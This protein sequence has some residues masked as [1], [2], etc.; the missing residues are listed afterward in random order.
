MSMD[1]KSVRHRFTV[2]TADTKVNEW[3]ENQSNLGFS[4][5]VLIKAFV[6]EYGYQDAT[7]LELG[8]EVKRRGRP[9]K[10]LK[11]Q[12]D[13]IYDDNYD[14]TT[15]AEPETEPVYKKPEPVQQKSETQPRVSTAT[16]QSNAKQHVVTQQP[17]VKLK[18]PEPVA[19]TENDDLMRM[20][21]SVVPT[22]P[23]P[24]AEPVAA[25]SETNTDDDGFVDPESLF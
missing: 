18:Q 4:L 12:V 16:D 23:M 19:E 22:T 15:Y 11:N 6:K 17:F 5:R 10:I 2:P 25:S 7:C 9:P 1:E 3:I 20:M 14:S 24:A 8:T 21:G 13:T